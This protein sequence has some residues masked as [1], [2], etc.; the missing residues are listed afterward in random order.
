M[1]GQEKTGLGSDRQELEL[2]LVCVSRMGG[3]WSGG[4]KVQATDSSVALG[5]SSLAWVPSSPL[6]KSGDFMQAV[7]IYCLPTL[8]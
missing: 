7:D 3:T 8:G 1:W 6:V 2:Q 4:L 5:T